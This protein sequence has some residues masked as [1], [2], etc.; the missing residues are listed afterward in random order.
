MHSGILLVDKPRG[1]TSHDVVA[2]VRRLTGIRQV[3]HT[4]TLDPDASGV[5]VICIGRTTRLARFFEALE[6]TY[7]VVMRLGI[8]T[9][10]Q[11][12]MG[13]VTERAQVPD[14][15]RAELAAVLQQFTG[16]QHQIP[17]MYS[18]VKYRG[19]RL[20]HLARQ[21]HTVVRQA[22]AIVI[23]RCDLLDARGAWITFVVTCSKGTYVRTLCD[24]IGLTLGCGAHLAHLQ[25]CQVGPF[26]LSQAYTLPFLQQQAHAGTLAQLLIPAIEALHFLPRLTL[27]AQQDT[28]LQRAQGSALSTLLQR[29]AQSLPH[30][31]CYR[32]YS[33]TRGTFAVM[34]RPIPTVEKWKLYYLESREAGVVVQSHAA[35]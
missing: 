27:T 21:G 19:Q 30:A 2:V 12:A 35:I 26:R 34:Y 20:Y 5:L 8:R 10:T 33:P 3:G 4:G 18:A 23:R 1:M 25:R 11:D 31:S 17:P 24:D 15:F 16:P 7:W 28:A 22:R 13:A 9:D 32:L 29:M 14:I 6:K